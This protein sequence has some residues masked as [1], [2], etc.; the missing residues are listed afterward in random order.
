ML[1]DALPQG[2]PAPIR[3]RILAALALGTLL[4]MSAASAARA[5]FGPTILADLLAAGA[6]ATAMLPLLVRAGPPPAPVAIAERTPATIEHPPPPPSAPAVA[7]ELERYREVAGILHAQVNGAIADTE[8]AALGLIQELNALEGATRALMEDLAKAEE[9]GARLNQ[10]GQ[11]DVEGMREAMEQLRDRLS[12]RSAQIEGDRAIYERI[13][14]EA[15]GFTRAI[16]DIGSIA[17]QTR[18]LALNATIEAA[19]AGEAGK[20]FAVVAQE[21]RELAGQTTKVAEGVTSGLARLR[22]LMRARMSDALDTAADHSLLDTAR[23]QAA[24]AV[25]AFE[26][27]ASGSTIA[28]QSTGLHGQGIGGHITQALGA[29]QFQDI[30]RQRLEQVGEAIERLGLHAGWL[31]EALHERRSVE[32][33]ES[34]LL[35]RMEESYVMHGQRL[36]H[37]NTSGSGG[38]AVELF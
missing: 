19:R 4:S 20:G 1:F 2:S 30:V 17:Q 27:M 16:S 5:L 14:Q 34:T 23:Q 8:G 7:A 3:S 38:P 32:S 26:R 33:V 37:G 24:G 15:E 6:F 25:L 18:L 13:A 35:R 21:V 11:E 10:A 36:V 22:D 31:A 28:L 9:A 12:V 29:M